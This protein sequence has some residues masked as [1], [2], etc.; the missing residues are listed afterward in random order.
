MPI[1][2]HKALTFRASSIGD[3]LMGKYLLENIHA[4]FPQARLGIVVASRAGMIRELFAAYSWLEV[5]EANRR[6]SVSLFSLWKKFHESDLV[7][8]QYA[9]KQGGSFSLASK[10][11]ARVLARRGGLV[12]FTD[13]SWWNRML[14]DRLVP[15]RSDIAVAEHDRA[16]LHAAGLPVSLPF[17][18]LAYLRDDAVLKKF[19]LETR[20][21]IVVHLFAGNASRGLRPDKKRELLAALARKLS[22]VR[23]VISGGA[24]DREESTRIT[25]HIPATVIAGEAT[26]QELM[27]LI[28]ESRGVVSVDTGVAHIAAQLRKPL[29]VLRTCVG[30]QWWFPGQYGG[31]APITVFSCD[32]KCAAGHMNRD[33]PACVNAI[34]MEEVARTVSIVPL[35]VAGYN[36]PTAG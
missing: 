34:D 8:T 31:D 13:A 9:G 1:S 22:G 21:F 30:R 11:A 23:L 25:E 33:Y 7:V 20:K 24:T 2:M 15:I 5:I 10:L 17:P 19:H 36:H 18:T 16:A 29:V 4:E 28:A 12:G 14:Y 32:E 26:L 6:H 27:N 35:P 3:C